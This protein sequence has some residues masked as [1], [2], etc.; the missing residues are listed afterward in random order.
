M[1]FV[2]EK[3]GKLEEAK[4]MYEKAINK[5]EN[6]PNGY[7]HLAKFYQANNNMLKAYKKFYMGVFEDEEEAC[8]ELQKAKNSLEKDIDAQIYKPEI[9]LEIDK[10]SNKYCKN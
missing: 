10:L 7:Y 4:K 9:K 1:A 3:K 2:L 5:D 8:E 6:D